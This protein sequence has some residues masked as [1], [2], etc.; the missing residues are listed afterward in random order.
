MKQIV[1]CVYKNKELMAV[2]KEFYES[3]YDA[4]LALER[5]LKMSEVD[6]VLVRKV[7]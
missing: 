1:L 5:F 3:E 6:F 4:G 2:D 7:L